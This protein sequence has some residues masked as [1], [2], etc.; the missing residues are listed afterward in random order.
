MEGGA[1]S[2]QT[3]RNDDP[4]FRSFLEQTPPDVV[5]IKPLGAYQEEIAAYFEKG[6][7]HFGAALPWSKTHDKFR[8]RP[9]E[10]TV[11][12]GFNF[13]GKSRLVGQMVLWLIQQDEPAL[14]AS[15]EMRPVHTAVRIIRQAAGTNQPT[16]EWQKMFLEWVGDR[17][18]VYD[19]YGEV[20]AKRMLDIAR[21]AA[22]K[23]G[24]KHIVVD[25]LMK[26]KIDKDDYQGQKSI[27]N[28]LQNVAQNHNCHVHLVAHLKKEGGEYRKPS[29]YDISG[30]A[31]ISD[32]ADNTV[33]VWKNVK[34]REMLDKRDLPLS[35]LE[36]YQDQPD[37]YLIVD[38]QRHGTGWTGSFQLWEH[39][40]SLQYLPSNTTKPMAYLMNY[41]P[42]AAA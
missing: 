19:Q 33:I 35:D 28:A 12:C 6:D 21:Y 3:L 38:K 9:G 13:H 20:N 4:G 7:E 36:K 11:W 2:F 39:A 34:K 17:I 16:R 37:C 15:M 26:V 29:R 27:V 8:V 40:P 10:L 25:S 1:L 32:Q 24:C 22:D 30:A 18:L 31:E 23:R 14:I 42:G 5:S 41:E